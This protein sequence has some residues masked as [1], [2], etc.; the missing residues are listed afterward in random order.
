MSGRSQGTG[1][2]Q[3]E[4]VRGAEYAL[5]R[6]AEYAFGLCKSFGR[7]SGRERDEVG[8]GACVR[9]AAPAPQHRIGQAL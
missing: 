5:F 4:V 1:W 8:A 2:W 7:V 6:G 9:A 3:V